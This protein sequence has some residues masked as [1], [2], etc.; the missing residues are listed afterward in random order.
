MGS[1]VLEY[2]SDEMPDQASK[3]AR[4]GIPDY[5]ADQYGS[6]DTLLTHWGITTDALYQ[7]MK[8]KLRRG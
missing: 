7:T 4:I 3:V 6:Q 8:K 5:F 1:A 2:C